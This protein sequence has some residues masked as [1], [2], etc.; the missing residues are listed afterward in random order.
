MEVVL[1]THHFASIGGAETY[2]LTTAEQ[3]QR[4][5][6]AVTVHSLELGEMAE[7]ARGRGVIVAEAEDDLPESCDAI[8]VQSAATSPLLAARYPDVPQVFVSHGI[9]YDATLPPQLPGLLS[10]AIALNDR[11]GARLRAGAA[12]HEV[13]RL[14]QPIDLDRFNPRGPLRSEPRVL[15][16]LGNYLR[17]G[18][19]AAL[20]AVC[21]EL[22]MECRQ[23]GWHG[24]KSHPRP[25]LEIADADIVV[26]YGRSALEGMA[27]GR[28][29]YVYD[30]GGG[31]GWVTAESYPALESNGFAGSAEGEVIDRERIRRDFRDYDPDMGLVNR[32]LARTHHEAIRHAADLVPILGSAA[33]PAI[34]ADAPALRELARLMRVQWGV[35][36]RAGLFR[37]E[38]E[39]LRER[40]Q[41]AERIAQ[42][43]ARRAADAEA[44]TAALMATRRYRTAVALAAPLDT[45]RRLRDS[46]PLARLRRFRRRG[47]AR[48]LG[49][50]AFRDESRFLPGLL[51]NLA[52]QVD[53]VVA[54]DDGSTDGSAALVRDHP[55]VLE[56]LEVRPGAQAELEDGRNHRA[57]TEA[58]WKH[59]ADWL[60]GVDADERLERGFRSRAEEE[61]ARAE[62]HGHPAVWVWFRELWDA[63]DQFRV[64]GIWGQ[65]RKACLFRSDPSH[66]FD[67]RRVHANW[68]SWPPPDGDYPQGDLNI[69]HLRMIR[70]EDRRRRVER[71]RRI[72]P[73]N[74]I[75]PQGYDYL[76]NEQGVQV[77]RLD[78][79]REYV[80]LGR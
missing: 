18:R 61:I 14:R 19:R 60:L 39:L 49:L 75:Q 10:T 54:L 22:G 30:H 68:A 66:R 65:K 28:A 80:P 34:T 11:V 15:L 12:G 16:M 31:D 4:L 6:H 23:I 24:D 43:S 71:Y 55:L 25:E 37:T 7:E 78:P 50:V 67:D 38:S 72:D 69:Y 36:G 20:E 79:G 57:L 44:R 33:R 26:G 21:E 3:L 52:T 29:V 5:G 73:D 17:G 1:S 64:D 77:R 35:E 32:E 74:A 45:A 8:L 62:T 9:V 76:L 63:P 56:L 40:V 42:E 51:E 48:V 27:A 58:A 46:R 41:E 53:G 2:L 70:P 47:P 13:V 59:G